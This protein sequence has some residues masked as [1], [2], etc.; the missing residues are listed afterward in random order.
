MGRRSAAKTAGCLATI[1][2]TVPVL[3]ADRLKTISRSLRIVGGWKFHSCPPSRRTRLFQSPRQ[4]MRKRRSGAFPSE[5][6]ISFRYLEILAGLLAR[7]DS[8]YTSAKARDRY[9]FPSL[10]RD[11]H[12]SLSA[13]TVGAS[14]C[15][16][17]KPLPIL[18]AVFP[19]MTRILR[20]SSGFARFSL[21]LSFSYLTTEQRGRSFATLL[22]G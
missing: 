9:P 17:R 10:I 3:I 8:R 22:P 4:S 2:L 11:P 14:L 15:Y 20:V 12:F 18:R 1:V 13:P 19:T 6:W 5:C 16:K 7:G 21:L